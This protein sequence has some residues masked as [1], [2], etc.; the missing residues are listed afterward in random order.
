M[1]HF[2][3]DAA[4]GS[5]LNS[6]STEGGPAFS[7]SGSWD[8]TTNVL[9]LSEDPTGSVSVGDYASLYESMAGTAQYVAQVTAVTSGSITLSAT[10]AVGTKPSSVGSIEC[11]VGGAWRGPGAAAF[12]FGFLSSALSTSLIQLN[13]KAS[14]DYE[15]GVTLTIS[16]T[17]WCR[18]YSSAV[19]DGGRAVLRRVSGTGTL[20]SVTATRVKLADLVLEQDPSLNS[21]CVYA[22]AVAAMDN[23]LV[24]N[25]GLSG[26]GTGA[27]CS[28]VD[29][30]AV[31]CNQNLSSTHGGFYS[32]VFTTFLRCRS[33]NSGMSG[34]YSSPG[35]AL[36]DCSVEA[37]EHGVR[38]GTNSTRVLASHCTFRRGA[39]SEPTALTG[40]GTAARFVVDRCV[41]SRFS[42]LLGGTLRN[43]FMT[44][45]AVHSVSDP[46]THLVDGEGR[47][48]LYP[49]AEPFEDGPAGDYTLTQAAVEAMGE[50]PARFFSTT[51][52]S[53]PVDHRPPGAE[54][55][56]P[57]ANRRTL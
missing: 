38:H 29:C 41:F 36:V 18:G 46:S 34:W 28:V 51:L 32:F 19:G 2:Y 44:R 47:G 10:L 31:D 13:L 56:A 54:P 39:D 16:S 6:G 8:A 22:S 24:R 57:P 40:G 50:A 17:L 4:A 43:T 25:A 14:A 55:A 30:E 21:Y 9:S 20:V 11:R 35:I 45:C 5:D 1:I 27:S 3:C 33:R 12:P 42:N 7:A 52:P 53:P 15:L 49:A 26:I 37:S 23:L 48:T